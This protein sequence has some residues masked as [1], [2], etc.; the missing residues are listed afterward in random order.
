MMNANSRC[1]ELSIDEKNLTAN[2][3]I[4]GDEQA[5]SFALGTSQMLS[6]GTSIS[7]DS[8]F[9]MGATDPTNTVETDANSNFIFSFNASSENY[10]SWRMQDLY[11]TINP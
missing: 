10:R 3:N 9:V 4:N 2:L 11:T 1:Q 6:N 5:Y 7:C 8:G